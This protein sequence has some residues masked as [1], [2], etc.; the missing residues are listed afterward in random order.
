MKSSSQ[1]ACHIFFQIKLQQFLCTNYPVCNGFMQN[2]HICRIVSARLLTK[3]HKSKIKFSSGLLKYLNLKILLILHY[4][5]A[6]NCVSQ[7]LPIICT[8]KE[9][10]NLIY[11]H[12]VILVNKET[13]IF[14]NPMQFLMQR[15]GSYQY[16]DEFNSA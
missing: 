3:S 9:H 6:P 12:P 13:F 14:L 5:L 10:T 7:P 1:V 11:C 2:I 15:K 16:L 8:V 4:R